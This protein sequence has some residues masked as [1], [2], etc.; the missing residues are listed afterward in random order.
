MS[1]V[2]STVAS[3]N[4]I[5]PIKPESIGASLKLNQLQQRFPGL[6]KELRLTQAEAEALFDL[7][8]QQEAAMLSTLNTRNID[9]SNPAA[10]QEL[11]R[12]QAELEKTQKAEFEAMLG[13]SKAR[14]WQEY[15]PTVEARRRVNELTMMLASSSPLTE[16][17]AAPLVANIVAEQKR[18]AE[19]ERLRT[20]VPGNT[21][22]QL[23]FEEQNLRL[24]EESNR[25]TVDA[26]R[27]YLNPE[28]LTLMQDSQKR[29]NDRTRASLQA[30]RERLESGLTP[31]AG[32]N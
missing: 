26:A 22:A 19:D 23:E 25:R 15:Q 13:P 30:R 24:R 3:A 17:Q 11:Q 31:D 10:R 29:I 28:Q 16:A 1:A 5:N 6:A 7:L 4:V 21:R 32:S 20:P 12:L 2:I 18:R 9:P 8:M 27:A 14:L